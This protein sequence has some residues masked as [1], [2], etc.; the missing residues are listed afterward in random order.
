MLE[1]NRGRGSINGND[2]FH[3]AQRAIAAIEA[4]ITLTNTPGE[5]HAVLNRDFPF[6]P[7]IDRRRGEYEYR[8]VV[9]GSGAGNEFETLVFVRSRDK[10][11][12]Q[13][14][15]DLAEHSFQTN[16]GLHH[17][18][19]GRIGALGPLPTINSFVMAATRNPG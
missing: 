12:G 7:G 4:G 5:L 10:L 6:N 15:I 9:T 11:S 14:V 16:T 18:Y 1:D 8:V 17:N 19:A 13:Q 2:T 3:A